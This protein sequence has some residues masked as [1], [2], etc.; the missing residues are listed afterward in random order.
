MPTPFLFD[1]HLDLSLN[2]VEFNRDLTMPLAEIRS[3]E[4]EMRDH[5]GRARNT[6]C[7][8][9]MRKAGIGLCVATQLARVDHHAWSPIAA[10]RS[11]AQA[12][13]M[14]QA[15]LAW[16]RCM[17]EAGQMVQ[18]LDPAA[19]QAHIARWQDALAR[20]DGSHE[21]L[22]IGYIL[23]LEGADS[24]VTVDYLHRAY[25][26]GLRAI[27]PA[28]YGPGVYANGHDS[29][30]KLNAR[31]RELIR[32][33]DRLGMILDVT[34]LCQDAFWEAIEIFQG[35]LWASHHNC[36]A[37]VDDPRQLND[38]QIRAI[39]ARDG[40]IGNALDA[41]MVVPGWI[42]GK[43]MPQ[44]SGATLAKA[45]DHI[46]HICQ[47]TGTT[48]HCGLGSDLDG[49]FGTEQTPMDVDS[50]ADMAR[51]GE[52]LQARGYSAEDVR[53][54]QYGNFLRVLMRAWGA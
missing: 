5:K 45:V 42:R 37:L 8:P 10:W 40:V 14:T 54:I 16:Y 49:G 48:R 28:H 18:L 47:L 24:L 21:S 1:A 12:W 26:Y 22:P 25:Q 3:L 4:T 23:S 13:S 34:H 33:A 46:D 11:P 51:Y 50:I 30:G 17:E 29:S 6:V 44:E 32:E 53:G 39:A 35:P 38:D 27:G 43:T 31:G 2:A 20:G 41:W 9:E 15:Q 36:R 19:V 7:L 52:L